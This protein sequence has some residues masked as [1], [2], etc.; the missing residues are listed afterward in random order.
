MHTPNPEIVTHADGSINHA[1]YQARARHMR[2]AQA[3]HLAGTA[4]TKQRSAVSALIG[5]LTSF[6][7]APAGLSASRAVHAGIAS[8]TTSR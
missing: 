7:A 2:S 3:H 1:Y 5:W 6:L 8:T 4:A